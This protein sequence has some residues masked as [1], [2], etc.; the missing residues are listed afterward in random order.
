MTRINTNVESMRGLRNIQKANNLLNTSM[1][2]LSTGLKINSGKDNPSGLIASEALRLQISTIEQSIKNNSRANNVIA[3]ADSALG[4][5][6]GLLAQIRG[7]V[8]E[9]LNVGALS[10]E[11]IEANQAQIDAALS[12]INRISSNTSFAGDKLIDG[13]KAFNASVST[14]DAPKLADYKI[15]QALLGSNSSLTID[16]RMTSQ[17]EKAQ[18]RYVGGALT[19][20][21]T[22]EIGGSKGNEAVSLGGSS[23]LA[24][25]KTAINSV[26]GNT[27]VTARI[28]SGYTIQKNAVAN[29]LTT[30]MTGANN[31]VVFTD[32]RATTTAGTN[33]SLGGGTVS[34]RFVDPGANNQPLSVSTTVDGDGNALVT[35]SLATNGGGSITTTASQLI[36]AVS[37]DATASQYVSVALASGNDGTGVVTALAQTALTGGTDAAAISFT[38]KRTEG[39]AGT[40]SIVLTNPGVASSPLSVSVTRTGNDSVV[41]VS[42][43]TNAS[44]QLISTYSQIKAA[45]EAHAV[46]KSLVDVD[47]KGDGNAVAAA[48]SSTNLQQSTGT[49]VLESDDYGSS[50]FV[51][52]NVLSG[53]F[54]TTQSDGST[55]ARRDTGVDIGALI[56]GQVVQG[57]G[58][59]ALFRSNSID[60]EVTFAEAYNE[61][62]TKA[63]INITGGG[64]LFQI[65]QEANVAGQIGLGIEAVNT[66]RLGGVAGKLFELGTGGG[67]S[68]IDLRNSLNG[69]G[70]TVNPDDMVRIIE[71]AS[72]YVSSLRGRLGAIQKNVIE[73]NVTTLGVALENISEARSQ[74]TDTDFAEETAQLQKA[75]IL[76]QAGLSVLSIANQNP[77]QVLALLR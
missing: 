53:T 1:Q 76:T 71:D 3:T 23:T 51:N 40:V 65:G 67:K 34:V 39:S 41:N 72:N 75:Q 30:N 21:T 7:L 4:E 73:T 66:S 68:L 36:T 33:A 62:N 56:N 57:R 6:G 13:S 32:A 70:A 52:V 64:S 8:Q 25:I 12:A 50:A 38:D 2:R 55:V 46:A 15:N 20:A 47:V 42:L 17:A 9:G 10:Q 14:A 37:Q 63:T 45:I 11:E 26:S 19:T 43:A 44:N 35:V 16:A 48:L 22:I 27:G 60:A 5:I 59:R 28:I 24:Q 69:T 29:S 49:L 74:I 77:Q 61:V 31:D 54:E 58:L 18:L